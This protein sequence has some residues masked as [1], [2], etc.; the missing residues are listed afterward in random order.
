[1]HIYLN[2]ESKNTSCSNLLELVQELALEGKR[3]AGCLYSQTLKSKAGTMKGL[4][5]GVKVIEMFIPV[6]VMNPDMIWS[7]FNEVH[8]RAT[9]LHAGEAP[10]KSLASCMA[11]FQACPYFS[12]CHGGLFSENKNK[13]HV[14]T[15]NSIN[16]SMDLL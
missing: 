6:E 11:Y 7:L 13:V 14:S 9:E 15:I 5:S 16:E 4:E 1:M 8:N 3:F 2:G 10:R 12:S